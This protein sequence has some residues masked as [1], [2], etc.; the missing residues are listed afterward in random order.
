MRNRKGRFYNSAAAFAL[1]RIRQASNN[2]FE[3]G[4]LLQRESWIEATV[5]GSE[6]ALGELRGVQRFPHRAALMRS[7][8]Q[9]A[10][11]PGLFLEFGVFEGE[12][13]NFMLRT[14]KSLGRPE[15]GYGFDSF[16]GL[17][18]D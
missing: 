7:C 16:E 10:V 2:L 13:L 15:V 12:S 6:F 17:P 8:L 5:S 11:R 3:V 14:L 18:E 1:R 4:R 9:A